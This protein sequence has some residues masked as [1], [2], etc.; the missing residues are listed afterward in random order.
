MNF[1]ELKFDDKKTPTPLTL[2]SWHIYGIFSEQ[3]CIVRCTGCKGL[4]KAHKYRYHVCIILATGSQ[5]LGRLNRRLSKVLVTRDACLINKMIHYVTYL[6]K[7]T[8]KCPY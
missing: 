1:C 8:I 7:A 5:N 2:K 4:I 6:S 3:F